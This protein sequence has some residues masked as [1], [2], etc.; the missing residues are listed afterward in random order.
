VTQASSGARSVCRYARTGSGAATS[1]PGTYT[2]GGTCPYVCFFTDFS[3]SLETGRGMMLGG[4]GLVHGFRSSAGKYAVFLHFFFYHY[5]HATKASPRRG[6]SWRAPVRLAIKEENLDP[7]R[8][9]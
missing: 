2:A 9:I 6:G 3:H 7:L 8:R 5:S 4:Y 1:A